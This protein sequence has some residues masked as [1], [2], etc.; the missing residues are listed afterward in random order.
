M[1]TRLRVRVT[2]RAGRDRIDGVH[3]GV[4]RI[5]LAAPPVEGQANE[6]LVR[7]LARTLG[8]PLRDVRVV[9][10]QTGREKLVEVDGLQEAEVWHRLRPAAQHT[11]GSAG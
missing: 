8:V 3:E 1:S 9:R 6:A 11:P 5:R 7:L 4:L 2:P 10:G